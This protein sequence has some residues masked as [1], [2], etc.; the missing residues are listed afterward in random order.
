MRLA[1]SALPVAQGGGGEAELGGKLFLGHVH[2]GAQ[3]LHIHRAGA[4][5]AYAPAAPLRMGDGFLQAL[6]DAVECGAHFVRPFLFQRPTSNLVS[7]DNSLRSAL[8]RLALS[9]L[10]NRVSRYSGICSS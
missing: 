6:F 7:S 1:V 5:H 10:A 4:M 9:P 3:G 8:L 2:L